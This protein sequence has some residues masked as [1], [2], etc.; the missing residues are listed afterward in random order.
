MVE[1]IN[2][3][4]QLAGFTTR[5]VR[6]PWMRC[7]KMVSLGQAHSLFAMIKTPNRQLRYQFPRNKN[8]YLFRGDYVIFYNK[9]HG[10]FDYIEQLAQQ[11]NNNEVTLP[12]PK[13]GFGGPTGYVITKRLLAHGLLTKNVNKLP[14]AIRLMNKNRLDG[15]L[16]DKYIG[17]YQLQSNKDAQNITHSDTVAYSDLWYAPFNKQFYEK[18]KKEIDKFWSVLPELRNNFEQRLIADTAKQQIDK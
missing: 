11:L 16:I 15:F 10:N 14:N 6:R 5:F 18:H 4:G 9:L 8:N 3:A 13:F 1:L 12:L 7:Q 17:L 2:K